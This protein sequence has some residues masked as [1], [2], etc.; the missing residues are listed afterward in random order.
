MHLKENDDVYSD[1]FERQLIIKQT[2]NLFPTSF[3]S[4]V[5]GRHGHPIFIGG[6][7]SDALP[8][9]LYFLASDGL[10]QAWKLYKDTTDSFFL[11]LIAGDDDA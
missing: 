1:D 9:G 4:E 6:W 5:A 7:A 10:H 11:S 2:G 3:N 8:E